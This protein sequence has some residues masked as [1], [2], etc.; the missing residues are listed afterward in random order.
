M[1]AYYLYHQ[2]AT[3]NPTL[4][5]AR[6]FFCRPAEIGSNFGGLGCLGVIFCSSRAEEGVVRLDLWWKECKIQNGS[7]AAVIMPLRVKRK[8]GPRAEVVGSPLQQ[9]S[10]ENLPPLRCEREAVWKTSFRVRVHVMS[11]P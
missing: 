6:H 8:I 11:D 2:L 5:E 7:T 10:F 1:Q 3:G 9:S 4:V